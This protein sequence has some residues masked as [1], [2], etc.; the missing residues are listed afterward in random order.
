MAN[1][2][3]TVAMLPEGVTEA[4]VSAVYGGRGVVTIPDF[5]FIEAFRAP[6]AR[7][8][9]VNCLSMTYVKTAQRDFPVECC[10]LILAEKAK[11][12]Q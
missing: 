6:L 1:V 7:E 8:R 2:P 12:S 10:R 9:Y 3:L 4:E 5:L 11:P